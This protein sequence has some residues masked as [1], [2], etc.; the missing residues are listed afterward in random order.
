MVIR[1]YASQLAAYGFSAEHAT[2]VKNVTCWLHL[3][4]QGSWCRL[5]SNARQ[6]L[7]AAVEYWC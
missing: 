5:L 7:E 3:P 6:V 1:K 2:G 4:L